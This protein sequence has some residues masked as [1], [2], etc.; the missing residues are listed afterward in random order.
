MSKLEGA[1]PITLDNATFN[2]LVATD[3]SLLSKVESP[4]TTTVNDGN[5]ALTIAETDCTWLVRANFSVEMAPLSVLFEPMRCETAVLALVSND[6][7]AV[8]ADAST[9][10]AVDMLEFVEV[11]VDV[12]SVN[13]VDKPVMALLNVVDS[14][15][16]SSDMV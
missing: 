5:V 10:M 14:A 2:A 8:R 1:F 16:K 11:M 4:D 12:V 9:E 15:S 13:E 3:I 7:S 6:A